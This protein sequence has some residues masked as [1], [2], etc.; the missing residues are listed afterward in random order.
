MNP[1]VDTIGFRAR[2][3]MPQSSVDA[4]EAQQPGFVAYRLRLR[5]S[6]LNAA[7][8]K[9]YGDAKNLGNSL[10]FGQV[11]PTLVPQGTLPPGVSLIGRPSLGSMLI[12]IQI[13]TAGALGTARFAWTKDAGNPAALWLPDLP[14]ALE[15]GSGLG[16]L[17]AASVAL[18]G[19]GLTAQFASGTNY[20]TDNLYQADTPVPGAVIAWLVSMVTGD[21]LVR[22]GT[23]PADSGAQMFFD[24]RDRAVA[25]IKEAADGK[26]GLLDLPVSEDQGSAVTTGG[27]MSYSESSPYTWTDKEACAARYEDGV[28]SGE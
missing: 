4:V 21:V 27:V 5:S 8:R 3:L 2:T 25:Q 26:D 7:A 22:L 9:R 28:W 19:T 18:P 24:D 12:S 15:A 1:Y 6:E 13:V 14:A 17:T 23:N 10:P 16:I 11:A 20:S